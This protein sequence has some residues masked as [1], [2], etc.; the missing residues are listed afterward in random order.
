MS[1]YSSQVTEAANYLRRILN[2]KDSREKDPVL[3]MVLGSGW[4]EFAGSLEDRIEIPFDRIPHF[5]QPTV[6]GHVGALVWGR[7]HGQPVCCLQGRV[8]SYEG[9]P[10]QVVTFPVRVLG[11]LGVRALILTNAAGGINP[12][13][14]P[15]DLMLI[16]DHLSSFVPNPLVGP[17]EDSVGTR[18][19]DMSECYSP[20]LRGLA[21]R[22]AR[23]SNLRLL[24]GVYVAVTG[25]SYETPSEIRMF[26]KLGAD[27][28]GMST[29][30][31]AIVVR[32]MGIECLGISLITN[33]AAGI[34]KAPLSHGEVL[35]AGEKV[36]ARL[37]RFLSSL[38][39][40]W[41]ELG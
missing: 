17:H 34:S 21:A 37:G 7:I 41:L 25:P 5:P 4:G 31:E 36:K 27:A 3:G 24:E 12:R 10:P 40:E 14:R 32:H 29:V 39:R 22:C 2:R 1:D 30:P 20:R 18:F 23:R 26:R 35:K 9:Q 28:I 6:V 15:G 19:T 8:H 38:C 16:R 11:Q 13:L 33:L